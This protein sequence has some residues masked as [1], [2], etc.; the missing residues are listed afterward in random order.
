MKDLCQRHFS[1]VWERYVLRCKSSIRPKQV[2]DMPPTHYRR[3]LDGFSLKSEQPVSRQ[4]VNS[5]PAVGRQSADCR[6]TRWPT[7]WPTRRWDRILY[8]YFPLWVPYFGCHF[9]KY[10]FLE[11]YGNHTY[12][13]NALWSMLLLGHRG[14]SFKRS[15][16]VFYIFIL[17][18]FC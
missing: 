4:S 3:I 17:F 5:R 8:L 10:S 2:T 11:D 14:N 1:S 12:T 13:H 16:A 6:P 7:C 15:F 9:E 18:L